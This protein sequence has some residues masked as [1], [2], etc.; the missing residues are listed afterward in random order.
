[1]TPLNGWEKTSSAF[2]YELR[3]RRYAQTPETW[4]E[5]V[6]LGLTLWQG[7][8]E[9]RQDTWL[10]WCDRDGS[11]L[12]TGDE[13]ASKAEQ[14]VAQAESALEQERQRAERAEQVQ[15]A[16]VVQLLKLGLSQE[17]VANTLGLSVQEVEQIT[18]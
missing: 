8:L 17:Q 4:L 5:Q 13:R 2:I 3:G 10:R 9:G 7:E 14:R 15:R 11:V 18:F 1:M 6:G 16:A 12:P